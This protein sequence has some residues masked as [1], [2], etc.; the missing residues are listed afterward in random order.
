VGAFCIPARHADR[1]HAWAPAARLALIGLSAQNVSCSEPDERANQ[2]YGAKNQ[3]RPSHSSAVKLNTGSSEIERRGQRKY[4]KNNSDKRPVDVHGRPLAVLPPSRSQGR[5]CLSRMLFTVMAVTTR[6]HENADTPISSRLRHLSRSCPMQ[7]YLWEIIV[8]L[9]QGAGP[10]ARRAA[11]RQGRAFHP[12][13]RQQT[14]GSTR[15]SA[16]PPGAGSAAMTG[17]Q[18]EIRIDG[19]PRT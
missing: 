2:R 3:H 11:G 8:F 14:A 9:S 12:L 4:E 1:S 5:Y 7:R 16:A 10:P 19:M 17:A 13:P 15:R 18:C 6:N